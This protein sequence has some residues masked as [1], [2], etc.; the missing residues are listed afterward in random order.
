MGVCPR[1]PLFGLVARHN[2]VSC[3]ASATL[4][5]L[6]FTGER[7]VPKESPLQDSQGLTRRPHGRRRTEGPITRCGP[8][9]SWFRPSTFT[10]RGHDSILA[11]Q[12][13][14]C[15]CPLFGLVARRHAGTSRAARRRS[16]CARR[17]RRDGAHKVLIRATPRVSNTPA[18]RVCEPF[19]CPAFFSRKESGKRRRLHR[20]ALSDEGPIT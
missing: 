5:H 7:K 12:H 4:L 11:K 6:S 19:L 16:V 3:G 18:V 10:S 20:N 8:H 13:L 1:V 17:G 2:P 9:G 14:A 15:Q